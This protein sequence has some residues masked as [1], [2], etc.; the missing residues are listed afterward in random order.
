M[1]YFRDVFADDK[2]TGG[3]NWFSS[4]STRLTD[5]IHSLFHV[6]GSVSNP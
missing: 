1:G 5:T 2:D 4:T 3:S 6:S